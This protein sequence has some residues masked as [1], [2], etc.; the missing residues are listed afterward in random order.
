MK[1]LLTVGYQGA[2]VAAL[3]DT[4]KAAGANVLIDVRSAP[5]SRRPEF[6]KA[7]LSESISAAGLRYIHMKALGNPWEGREAA[8]SGDMDAYRRVFMA[9]LDSAPTRAA[10][11]EASGIA[12]N[13]TACLMCLEADPAHCHRSMVAAA[14]APLGPF[15]IRHLAIERP[16]KPAAQ[17]SLPFD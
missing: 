13:E 14:L 5:V 1:P 15:E 16:K 4:L 17:G 7:A 10:L 2:S 12:T 6:A 9:H 3:I 11:A 8:K